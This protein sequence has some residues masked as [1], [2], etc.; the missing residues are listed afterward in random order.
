[1]KTLKRFF[2]INLVMS[3][4][5]IWSFPVTA[6]EPAF[7]F[8]YNGTEYPPEKLPHQL[9]KLY[10]EAENQAYEL[11]RQ[12]ADMALF[13]IFLT[14]E[15]I[16]Q[17]KTK[18]VVELELLT[19]NQPT[20]AQIIRFYQERASRINMS[21]DQIRPR[22]VRYLIDQQIEEKRSKILSRLKNEGDFKLNLTRPAEPRFDIKTGGYPY[23]GGSGASVVIVEF[24]DYQCPHCRRASFDLK[25]VIKKYGDKVRLVYRDFPI[26]RSGISRRI[27]E[28]GVCAQAQ[29][30]FWEYHDMA[31]QEQAGLNNDSPAEFA[32]ILGLK[33]MDFSACLDSSHTKD[34]VAASKQE[35]DALGIDATPA[36]FINGKNLGPQ[37]SPSNMEKIIDAEL[38]S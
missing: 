4:T 27:A 23:K 5:L 24:A 6:A 14:A 25:K 37:I 1:M 21:M 32:E 13:D 36:I 2:F 19:Y 35:G 30:K 3:L 16:R 20:D 31:F 18:R 12:V 10:F 29:G 38:K 15:A 33:M 7:L 9:K 28:G 17:G 22:I 8:S 26:N 34:R 11:E